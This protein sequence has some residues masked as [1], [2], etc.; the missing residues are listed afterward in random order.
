M[1]VTGIYFSQNY[2]CLSDI[3]SGTPLFY[4][5]I[6][7]AITLLPVVLH[8]SFSGVTAVQNRTD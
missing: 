4:N 7:E 2:V 5:Y 3:F 6:F 8:L 1:S